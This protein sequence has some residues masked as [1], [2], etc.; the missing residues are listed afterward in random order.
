MFYKWLNIYS[1]ISGLG[2]LWA[3]TTLLTTLIKMFLFTILVVTHGVVFFLFFFNVPTTGM[4]Y[5]I[6]CHRAHDL[7]L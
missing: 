7:H 2:D 4:E 3:Q 5:M 6:T 1:C